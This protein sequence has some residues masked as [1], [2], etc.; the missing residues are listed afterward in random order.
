MV[1]ARRQGN[2]LISVLWVIVV[3]VIL[4]MGLSYEARSDIE[5]TMLYRDRAR[6]YWLARAAVERVKYDHAAAKVQAIN[7]GDQKDKRVR[8]RYDFTDGWAEC[9]L[10]SDAAKMNINSQNREQW[11]QLFRMYGVDDQEADEITDAIL[12]WRDADDLTQLNG[13]EADYYQSLTPPYSPRNAPFF[14]VEEIMLVRGITEAMYYGSTVAGEQVPGL[15]DLLMVSSTN[16]NRFDI[17]TCPRGLLMAFLEIGGMEADQIIRAREEK[18]F[19]NVDEVNQIVA[20]NNPENLTKYFMPFA[21]Q[22]AF[23]VRATA[24]VRG[25]RARYT[26]EAKIRYVGGSQLYT[27]ESYKDFS[28]DHVDESSLEE[29]EL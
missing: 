26:V 16:L 17:N 5:R 12:D 14:T 6:A 29:E 20:V 25:S 22:S 3:M 15:K 1:I 9:I 10:L 27:Y 21:G 7:M 8:F 24:Y 4:V 18:M 19:E 28:L 13:A 2:V 23:T 11:K